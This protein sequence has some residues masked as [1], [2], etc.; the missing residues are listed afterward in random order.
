MELHRLT[1]HQARARLERGEISATELTRAVLDRIDAVDAHV[2][3]YLTV[4]AERALDQARDA[5]ARWVEHR[6]NGTRAP[7]QLG[8]PMAIKDEV[9]T[10]GVRT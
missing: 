3:A 6:K 5:D 8:I 4:V 2:R 1:I 9:C 10:R 7:A